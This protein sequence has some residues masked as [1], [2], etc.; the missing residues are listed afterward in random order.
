[1]EVVLTVYEHTYSH[2]CHYLKIISWIGYILWEKQTQT[3]L[4]QMYL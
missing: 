2:L 4:A 3:A 1:M